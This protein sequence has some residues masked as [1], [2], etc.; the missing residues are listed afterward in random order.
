MSSPNRITQI[1]TW[2]SNL[3]QHPVNP[4]LKRLSF[5][6]TMC[7][8]PINE[9]TSLSIRGFALD[10]GQGTYS[11]RED[12]MH[13]MMQMCSVVCATSKK[14]EG[15]A[16]EDEDVTVFFIFDGKLISI[17]PIL[18]SVSNLISVKG[19]GKCVRFVEFQHPY[20]INS[21]L[22]PKNAFRRWD[23]PKEYCSEE[24][25]GEYNLRSAIIYTSDPKV[26]DAY[27]QMFIDE[28]ISR[29]E[30]SLFDY[31]N[32]QNMTCHVFNNY[33]IYY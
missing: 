3:E 16:P 15:D 33:C 20:N 6:E 18:D 10:F 29:S 4:N 5:N 12:I 21:D 26:D 19:Y 11:P 24:K 32:E 17:S 31:E 2:F 27:V 22:T 14:M 1:S 28:F 8:T 7:S 23:L 13:K 30:L 9:T 25:E